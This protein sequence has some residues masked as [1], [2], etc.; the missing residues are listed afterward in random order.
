[1]SGQVHPIDVTAIDMKNASGQVHPEEQGIATNQ[2]GMETRKSRQ[3]R[4]LSRKA[5]SFQK[6]QMFTNVCCI[7]LCPLMMVVIS[8]GLGTL[9]NSLISRSATVERILY[10]GREA[11]LNDA[12]FPIFN[13]SD[14][15]V[16]GFDSSDG[17]VVNFM[18]FSASAVGTGLGG[19][20]Y[21]CVYWLGASY[22]KNSDVYE[23]N[24]ALKGFP[25]LDSTYI[26]PPDG[27]WLAAVG[28]LAAKKSP[29]LIPL[30]SQYS[31][32][33]SNQ[34]ILAAS[35]SDASK[36]L[37][38][39]P[40]LPLL[41]ILD[42]QKFGMASVNAS[43]ANWASSAVDG[44]GYYGLLGSFETRLWA[45][46]STADLSSL[47]FNRVPYAKKLKTDSDDSLDDEVSSLLSAVI[48]DLSNLDKKA[49]T[50]RQS[51]TSDL[52]AFYANAAEVTKNM[53]YGALWLDRFS[54]SE[55]SMKAIL[56]FGEDPRITA[57]GNFPS[58]G[59]RQ[60]IV[61]SQL[62]QASLRGLSDVK[63]ANATVTQ[64]VR[65][66][67]QSKST[68]I[69]IQ[70][71]GLIGGI[72]Y[73]FGVS[74]LL[75]IFTI[76]LVKEKE[77]RIYI[78]MKLNGLKSMT[79]YLSHYLVFFILYIMSAVI[80]IITGRFSGLTFFTLTELPVLVIMFF[81]WGHV[82]IVL[83]FLFSTFFNKNRI[84][85]VLV[86]L[87][88]LLGVIISL[89]SDTLVGQSASSAFLIWPPFGFYRALNIINKSSY[90]STSVPY[91][92][93]ML[94]PGDEVFKIMCFLVVEVFAYALIAIYLSFVAP[95]EF[96]T[97]YAW[98]FPIT[99]P[100]ATIQKRRRR[101]LNH[102]IDPLA[103]SQLALTVVINAAETQFEDSD[104]KAEKVRVE[105]GEYARD[106]PLVVSHMRKIYASRKGLGPKFA[107]K[108]VS[109]A[110]EKG[111][112]FGL[113]G[114]NG[115][116]KTTLISI[117][118]GLYPPSSGN[119][120][121]AGFDI[122][123][124]SSDICKVMGI[125]PQFDILWEDLTI[126]EHLYFYA[127]LKGATASEEKQYVAKALANV[128]LTS[129]KDRQSK[130]LSG[131][132]KRRLSIAIALIGTPKVVF[133]D[134]PTTGLDPQVRRL[135]WNIVHDARE[136]KAVILTTHS[137]EEAEAL[138][139]K[140]GIMAKGTLRCYGNSLRLKEL[141]GT[142]FRLYFNADAADMER[143]C[144]WVE[145]LLPA[146]FTKGDAFSTMTSYEFPSTG[147]AVS[148][149]FANMEAG[150]VA[151]GVLDWGIS[152]TSLEDVF[153]KIISEDDA[154]AD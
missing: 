13:S 79:Y 149:I 71:G 117:L 140:I 101:R 65:A 8:A 145:A 112:V 84:A 40:E 121:I 25:K 107:V 73:P 114:P 124:D 150:K 37:G 53:P 127:R 105:T 143:A 76:M 91:K 153:I 151:N 27:G 77:D 39:R 132:E 33:Q 100:I 139:Q 154:N 29:D 94:K 56:H 31:K 34:W 106:S 125:C 4:A 36:Y 68:E 22:P 137:M 109:F 57:S 129:L 82:Q 152:Q 97:S 99:L 86:F 133:F 118:T 102:G 63:Y 78:M 7:C 45:K 116:G 131:G 52:L 69:S 15:R 148:A 3:F 83:A 96:G 123:R 55:L 44:T 136:D 75:P 51:S 130:R 135:I 92:L 66:F 12:G 38:E 49:I 70:A 60:L 21:P 5:I 108:D 20:N 18:R 61:A 120:T 54:P 87:I 72:L 58:Q 14:S 42:A 90:T 2:P 26:P 115:A 41:S 113:L 85:L 32:L 19:K 23:K 95:S 141:Y 46:L 81:I 24:A 1:M 98:H 62:G 11:S 122:R 110:A 59:L 89:A 30:Q 144:K 147:S 128:S 10:C 93:S 48:K 50:N 138:C 16:F 64:G 119:A 146:G 88:V 134:E 103:E 126:E 111:T 104:V 28:T 9:I 67:P 142:G 74:F 6:R 47:T 43:F 17:K 35:S 80:F